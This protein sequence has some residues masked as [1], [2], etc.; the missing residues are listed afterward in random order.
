[1]DNSVSHDVAFDYSGMETDA[2]GK[3]H[4]IA[5]RVNAH[6]AKVAGELLQIATEVSK[7]RG[8]LAAVGRDGLFTAWVKSECHFSHSQAYRFISIFDAFA[9]CEEI[10]Q[11]EDSAVRRLANPATP[12]EVL[13]GAKTIAKQGNFV[14]LDTVKEMVA[15]W[16]ANNVD[17]DDEPETV[18]VYEEDSEYDEPEMDTRRG[19][20]SAKDE[21][22]AG[23]DYAGQPRVDKAPRSDRN[24]TGTH[25][26]PYDFSKWEKFVLKMVDMI[27]EAA[28]ELNAGSSKRQDAQHLLRDLDDMVVSW[29]R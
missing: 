3:L 16:K 13:D 28:T 24:A 12:Q 6:R 5:K 7:A 21:A 26:A 8:V 9:G 19:D 15:S 17:E 25:V 20:T 18:E 23:G 14:S 27:D 11:F 2:V 22:I 4:G 1:V 10:A 29:D